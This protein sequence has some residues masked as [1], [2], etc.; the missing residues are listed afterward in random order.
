MSSVCGVSLVVAGH[1]LMPCV[2][3]VMAWLT[4]A[5]SLRKHAP[6]G[7]AMPANAKRQTCVGDGVRLQVRGCAR[8]RGVA[9]LR[10]Q[11]CAQVGVG[12]HRSQRRSGSARRDWS[13]H[14]PQPHALALLAIR[15][16]GFV[17]AVRLRGSPGG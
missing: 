1:P 4:S 3:F 2:G 6:V 9:C 15:G 12:R 17:R 14:P 8:R 7:C 10:I 13:R 11:G 5:A 16:G